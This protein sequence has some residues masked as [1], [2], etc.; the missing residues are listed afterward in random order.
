ME[1]AK[2]IITFVSTERPSLTRFLELGK[3]LLKEST[4][5]ETKVLQVLEIALTED[6]ISETR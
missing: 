5:K 4:L 1:N 2:D 6:F 3:T